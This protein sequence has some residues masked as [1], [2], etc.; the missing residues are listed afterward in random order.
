MKVG[1]P[2]YEKLMKKWSDEEWKS[3]INVDYETYLENEDY[4]GRL[5]K[6]EEVTK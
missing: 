1:S 2:E 4:H 3:E 5:K 6:N